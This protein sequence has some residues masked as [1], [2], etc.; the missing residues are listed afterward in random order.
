MKKA[1]MFI[2]GCFCLAFAQSL[3]GAQVTLLTEGFDDIFSEDITDLIGKG[4]TQINHSEPLGD[5]DWFQGSDII[6]FPAYAG[7]PDSYIAANYNSTTAVGTISNWLITPPLDLANTKISFWTRSYAHFP[8]RLEVRL[9]T[10]GSSSDVGLTSA[11]V[12]DFTTLLLSINP[13]LEAGGYPN[14]WTKYTIANI[15]GSGTGRIAFRYYVTDGGWDIDL[16]ANS[17]YIGIDSVSVSKEV[18]TLTV[19]VTGQGSGT[20]TSS[21]AGI[22]CPAG[23]SETF[24]YGTT[25]A[26][27]PVP[28]LGSKFA[29]WNGDAD[30]K[31]GSVTITGDRNCTAI[32]EPATPWL[33]FLPAIVGH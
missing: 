1:G 8:D 9:S 18:Y 25:V 4:W 21:P 2:L 29:G 23:C 26:L 22:T 3:H 14:T 19:S 11:E 32:F 28:G 30:C 10:N 7:A 20:V 13:N 27:S 6:V 24:D 12:G 16:A 5:K 17:D 31:D 33:L 15:N